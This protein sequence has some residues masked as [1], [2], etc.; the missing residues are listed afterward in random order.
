MKEE[1]NLDGNWYLSEELNFDKKLIFYRYEASKEY[2][3]GPFGLELGSGS[4]EM[5]KYLVNE[6]DHLTSVDGSKELI[7]AIPNYENHTKLHSFFE[8]YKPKIKFNTII[9]EHILEHV[10]NPVEI[11]N[12]AKEW[13]DEDG[14]ILLGVPNALSFHRLAAVKMGL[15]KTPYELNERDF[16]V[17]HQRV[18]CADTLLRDIEKTGLKVK[19][20]SG[21]FFKP[22]SNGQIE[23]NW[24]EEMIKG[25]YELGKDFPNHCAELYA[26]LGK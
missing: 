18:Y 7:D 13:L 15:L 5:T 10:N 1:K 6:F 22:L 26:V 17:G 19:K 23:N 20:I 24:N 8:D 21:I 11:L 3:K 25:F 4:G 16:Q 14:V 9:M 2:I 12:L